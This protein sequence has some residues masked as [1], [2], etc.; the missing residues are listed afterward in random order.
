MAKTD[1]WIVVV[2]ALILAAGC[3]M[4]ED[5]IL[6][7]EV[8]QG[9]QFDGWADYPSVSADGRYVAFVTAGDYIPTLSGVRSPGD[10]LIHDRETGETVSIINMTDLRETYSSFLYPSLS[11]DGRYVAFEAI[12]PLTKTS[13]PADGKNP[14]HHICVID[15]VTWQADVVSRA[16]D[17]TPAND[18]TIDPV[19]SDD[20][21]YVTFSSGADNLVPGDTNTVLD[22]F[23]HDR[24]TGLTTRISVASDQTQANAASFPSWISGDGRWIVFASNADN[25]VTG[26]ENGE[27]DV[28]LYDSTSGETTLVPVPS[29]GV[30][31]QSSSI[32]P[33]ISGDGGSVV[34]RS[35]AETTASG[36]SGGVEILVYDRQPGS[37]ESITARSTGG[38]SR[39]PAISGTGRYI[40]FESAAALTPGDTN[41]R[42]DVFVFDTESET[43]TLVSVASDGIQ[44]N[45]DSGAPDI[46]A[47]GRYVI[48]VSKADNLVEGDTNG[49]ADIFVHDR[50][51]GRTTLVS[52]IG[53]FIDV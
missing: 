11:G 53:M 48:F 23:L 24:T 1:I 19:I 36:A 34:F 41:G 3:V 5:E 39:A 28:F 46:S 52:V 40:A 37:T 35:F 16:S 47:D 32:S 49:Y 42:D 44:G 51:S 18:R 7:K 20:G 10:I 50:I 9:T 22:V 33:A 21:R 4:G 15:R 8:V 14:F 12:A 13:Y 25:L 17:G 27:S 30:Q 31:R 29:A 6:P 2:F 38:W 26:D 45:G 43:T